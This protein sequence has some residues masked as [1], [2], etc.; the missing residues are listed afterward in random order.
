M[1]SNTPWG[2]VPGFRLDV[3][4]LLPSGSRFAFYLD[5]MSAISRHHRLFEPIVLISRPISWIR[6][7]IFLPAPSPIV[8]RSV[9]CSIWLR[10]R[11]ISSVMC[12]FFRHDSHFLKQTRLVDRHGTRQF[13]DSVPESF[14]IFA[15]HLRRP[16][17]YRF[18]NVSNQR[19]T[20]VDLC[21]LPFPCPHLRQR[22]HR[23]IKEFGQTL[24][25]DCRILN[26]F[27]RNKKTSL[28]PV[29]SPGKFDRQVGIPP[30]IGK[31]GRDNF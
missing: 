14:L 5:H 17:G 29:I 16:S 9:N 2:S 22:P 27:R 26:R 10:K 28:K 31:G 18:Q 15:N 12:A 24:P 20:G 7:S 19:E 23:F 8:S 4:R 11:T 1:I 3:L 21:S 6:K 13:P 25:E 30:S